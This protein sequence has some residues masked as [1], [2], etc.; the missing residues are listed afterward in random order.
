MSPKPLRASSPCFVLVARSPHSYFWRPIQHLVDPVRAL[1][2]G[3]SH[4]NRDIVS[5][6]YTSGFEQVYLEEWPN[7]INRLDSRDGVTLVTLTPPESLQAKT[8]DYDLYRYPAGSSNRKLVMLIEN[9]FCVR[10]RCLCCFVVP[11]INLE[12][13]HSILSWFLLLFR[14]WSYKPIVAGFAVKAASSQDP[15]GLASRSGGGGGMFGGWR[16]PQVAVPSPLTVAAGQQ[17]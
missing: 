8:I 4:V 16:M 13:M 6:V 9:Y 14:S 1:L 3:G 12:V 2:S 10:C 7:A 17:R 11:L 5:A 15:F